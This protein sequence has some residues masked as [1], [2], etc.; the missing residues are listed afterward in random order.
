MQIVLNSL[1][2]RVCK[3]QNCKSHCKSHFMSHCTQI[4]TT[5][6]F[7]YITDDFRWF[8]KSVT[9]SVFSL[10]L[11]MFCSTAAMSPVK[12]TANHDRSVLNFEVHYRSLKFMVRLNQRLSVQKFISKSSL[13]TFIKMN[14]LFGLLRCSYLIDMVRWLNCA[15]LV[16]HSIMHTFPTIVV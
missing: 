5:K 16:I 9:E 11:F 10:G 13:L 1:S 12:V 15:T 14:F 2:L 4:N 7:V 8:T 3:L 6:Y